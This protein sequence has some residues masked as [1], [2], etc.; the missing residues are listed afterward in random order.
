MSIFNDFVLDASDSFAEFACKEGFARV[1]RDGKT[2]IYVVQNQ[3]YP[4]GHKVSLAFTLDDFEPGN[5]NK[6]YGEPLILHP[7]DKIDF[8]GTTADY[9]VPKAPLWE[10]CFEAIRRT[11]ESAGMLPVVRALELLR[12]KGQKPSAADVAS[13]VQNCVADYHNRRALL[14][15]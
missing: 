4:G 7:A 12:S 13:A 5:A 8:L 6:L 3:K 9:L 14:I 10:T 1:T 2:D 11:P 15:A